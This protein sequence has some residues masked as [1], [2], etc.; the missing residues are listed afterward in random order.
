MLDDI[1][2][3]R[4]SKMCLLEWDLLGLKVESVCW[5]RDLLRLKERYNA[6]KLCNAR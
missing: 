2:I 5:K 1:M 4:E 6:R 3:E